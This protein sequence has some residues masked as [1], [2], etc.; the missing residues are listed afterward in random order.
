MSFEELMFTRAFVKKEADKYYRQ[1]KEID[2]EIERRY[3]QKI[4]KG[5]RENIYSERIKSMPKTD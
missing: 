5:R 3:E 4:E 2:E 1:L